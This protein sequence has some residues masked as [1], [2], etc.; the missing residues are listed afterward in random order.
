MSGKA[1]IRFEGVGLHRGV[2]SRIEVE[3]L[4]RAPLENCSY[5]FVS[6]GVEIPA[7]ASHATGESFRTVLQRDGIRVETVEHLLAALVCAEIHYARIEV[8]GPEIPILD[9]SAREFLR[10]LKSRAGKKACENEPLPIRHVVEVR[11]ESG[12]ARLEPALKLSF[13]LEFS[14]EFP[15]V[16]GKSV[17]MDFETSRW[18]EEVAPAR[19]F[20]FREQESV[21]R[22]MGLI[23]GVSLQ[24]CLVFRDG[25]VENPEGMRLEDEP[26]RHK[27][28][29][30]L[31]DL[32]LAGRPLRG[33][34][35]S[36]NPGHAR[37]QALVRKILAHPMG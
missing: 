6:K 11:D 33:R 5:T 22:Q 35:V 27:L 8:D 37:T 36:R 9:G 4:I 32:A 12:F 19:T 16:G 2:F 31:G 7:L 34:F 20:G 25:E 14:P 21:L 30:A 3:P 10:G 26:L 1:R 28:L 17:H 24:N 29:D 15:W 18:R 23:Q 13:L